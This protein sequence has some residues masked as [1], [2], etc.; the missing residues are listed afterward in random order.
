[1][2]LS[3]KLRPYLAKLRNIKFTRKRVLYTLAI[4]LLAFIV[5][6]FVYLVYLDAVVRDKFEGKRF[7]LPAKV[8]ARPLELYVGKKIKP[9][10]LEWELKLLRYSAVKNIKSSGQY[11]KSDERFLVY[12][13]AFTFWDASE[14]ASLWQVE[15]Q[16]DVV[17]SIVDA[18]SGNDRDLVRLEPLLIGGIYPDENEDRDLVR[19]EDLPRFFFDALV[20]VEDQ[21][22]YFHSGVDPKALARAFMVTVFGDGIQGGSTITQQLVKNFFLTPER[23]FSR[24][25]KEMLMSLII[26]MRYEKNDILEAYVNE[27]YFGQDRNRAIHGVALASDFYFGRSIE[28][29]ELHHAALLVAMLKGPA[30]YHPRRHPERALE[31]RDVV[32]QEMY[33]QGFIAEWEYKKAKSMSLDLSEED[34][35]GTSRYPAFLDLVFRQ[36]KQD[37]LEEDL[38]SEGLKIFTTLDPYV[39]S[40]AEK[41]LVSRLNTL[42]KKQGLET[43]VLQGALILSSAQ[44]GEV[45]AVVGGRNPSY[46]GF[47][48]ALDAK[49][50]VGSLL[51][52]AIYLSAL[53]KPNDYS[54]AT[55]LDDSPLVWEAPGAPAWQPNNYDKE[56]HDYVP[57]W[58]AFA[59]SYNV[60]A[61]RLGLE[62]GVDTVID[63]AQR[64]GIETEISPYASSLLGTSPLSVLEMTQMYQTLAS[65]GFKIPLR[66]IR[67]V[68]A[69]EGQPL[70][71][72]ALEVEQV[73][74]SEYAHLLHFALEKVVSEGTGKSLKQFLPLRVA[75]KT[76][77]TDD[78]KDSWFAGFSGDKVGVVWVG[79]DS[80]IN[81]G[82]SGATGA[83]TVW[84]DVFSQLAQKPVS[85][86]APG[87]IVSITTDRD[88]GARVKDNCGNT[89]VLP[90]IAETEPKKAAK[91]FSNEGKKD[92]KIRD[93]FRNF[94]GRD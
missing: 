54:L 25:F 79:S 74:K 13:K 26:E 87:N 15:L 9:E 65:G 2:K 50:Q 88:L 55:L 37:Y 85:E 36:L 52:P 64:L 31:R 78:Y 40:V 89:I 84:G 77:T 19:Y 29:M 47:N 86:S 92:G 62:L 22:F 93:W 81:T 27:V 28:Q 48:R 41:S 53:E 42:E 80:S 43:N 51:K 38:R 71:R 5:A 60:A 23:S 34:S 39:Q 94:L 44:T 90:Y 76:G 35:V 58:F 30:V 59:K 20:S 7:S 18:R 75:G 6:L 1:M 72:Y 8:Y 32:L 66:S 33:N 83:M 11:S 16:D 67:E 69:I 82:L 63:T 61:A 57:L 24:K 12:S 70:K 73:V 14:S 91:C 46:E 45:E 17:V 56:F 21:R 4:S 49:R 3:E 68:L 10:V